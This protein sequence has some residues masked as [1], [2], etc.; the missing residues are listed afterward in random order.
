MEVDERHRIARSGGSPRN[1]RLSRQ[2]SD[3]FREI[4]GFGLLGQSAGK[5]LHGLINMTR[6]RPCG[7]LRMRSGRSV[8]RLNARG[9]MIP[10]AR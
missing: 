3:R 10:V 4:H 2:T 6:R 5:H 8:Q 9:V 7:V 1:R